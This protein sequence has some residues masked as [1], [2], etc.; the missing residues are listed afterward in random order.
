MKPDLKA[1]WSQDQ[2]CLHRLLGADR[3]LNALMRAFPDDDFTGQLDVLYYG[4]DFFDHEVPYTHPELPKIHT[5]MGWRLR[6][7]E[8]HG[9][10]VRVLEGTRSHDRGQCKHWETIHQLMGSKVDFKYIDTLMIESHPVM[11]DVLYIPDNWRPTTDEVWLDVKA[12]LKAHNLEMVD[13][14]IMHGA[15]KHQ[16]PDHLEGKVQ[17]HDPERYSA[18]CR[19]YVLV[20][21]IH[22]RSQYKN[23][24]SAGSP[25]RLCHGEEE[26][27]GTLRIECNPHGEDLILF[28]ENIHAR[29]AKTIDVRGMSFDQ[30][31]DITSD[32]AHTQGDQDISLRLEV[33]PQDEICFNLKVLQNH[34]PGIEITLKKDKLN[35]VHL[36]NLSE[37]LKVTNIV[38]LSIENAT[39]ML[40]DFIGDELTPSI[41]EKVLEVMK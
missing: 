37:P 10:A 27:K 4:G 23:I 29:I 7:A 30:I 5:Y 31:L 38:D 28:Q 13:W 12:A 21:H 41:R 3:P 16:L 14:V 33:D 18:I 34:Y 6:M 32:F 22:L 8:K 11:G 2:H 39:K 1:G 36:I 20:G 35:K 40:L 19:K 25:E 26:P 9:Y 24:I 17:M 15:F